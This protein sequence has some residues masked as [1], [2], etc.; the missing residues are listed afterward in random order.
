[1]ILNDNIN[2]HTAVIPFKAYKPEYQTYSNCWLYHTQITLLLINLHAMQQHNND[3]TF[4]NPFI[5]QNR[6]IKVNPMQANN[7][8][9]INPFYY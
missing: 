4:I 7:D 3:H 9:T 8:D 2:I 1:M 5:T 6:K